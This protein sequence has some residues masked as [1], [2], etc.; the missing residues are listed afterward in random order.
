MQYLCQD[1]IYP[2]HSG[3]KGGNS[4]WNNP[5]EGIVW[6]TLMKRQRAKP[7]L[8]DLGAEIDKHAHA[9]RY[10]QKEPHTTVAS[11]T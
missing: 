2:G 10:L 9:Q 8:R 4:K 3:L 7:F 1:F 6:G 5:N 11:G